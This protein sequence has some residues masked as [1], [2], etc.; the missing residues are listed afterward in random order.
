MT[1]IIILLSLET[2]DSVYKINHLSHPQTRFKVDVD[3]KENRLRGFF[4]RGGSRI[5]WTSDVKEENQDEKH[6]NK[7][8]LVWQGTVA[9]QIFI[10]F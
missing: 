8:V 10:G 1:I 9:N 7:C 5:N 3:A 4:C 6:K 2:I